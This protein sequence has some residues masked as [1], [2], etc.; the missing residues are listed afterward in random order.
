MPDAVTVAIPVRNGGGLLREVLESLKRQQLDR[1]IELLVADSGSTDG[2]RQLAFSYGAEVIDIAQE[3]FSH[4]GTRNLLVERASGTHVALLTQDASPADDQWLAR[5]LDGFEAAD[6]VGLVFGRYRPRPGASVMVRR[7]LDG[8]FDALALEVRGLP[9]P[10][11]A[12]GPR[13]LFFTD[14]NGC[15]ARAAWERVP[16]REVPYA[17]D[18]RLAR[19]MLAAGYAKVYRPDATVIHSHDYSPVDHLRRTF[20]EWRG[21]REVQAISAPVPTRHLALSVQRAV[22]DDVALGRRE[23]QL[24]SAALRLGGLSLIHHALRA[25]GA[26]LGSRADRLPPYVTRACS[27]ERRAGFEPVLRSEPD[28]AEI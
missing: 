14:A 4:G 9:D 18:Q 20:D 22:R 5:L 10:D 6:D 1:K 19:D 8:W 23:G 15:V 12:D 25:V 7:E 11:E 28:E 21:L 26:T 2:S 17:E 13:R 27:L 24:G 3:E 16:F